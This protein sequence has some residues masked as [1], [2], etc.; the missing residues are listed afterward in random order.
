MKEKNKIKYMKL[1]IKVLVAILVVESIFLGY[2]M[3]MNRKNS[4]YYTIENDLVKTKDGYV[5]VGLSDM[6]YSKLN[7]YKKPGYTKATI[8]KLDNKFNQKE[9]K[10]LSIGYNS[11]Y[12]H[13]IETKDGYVAVGAIEMSKKHHEDKETEA[14]IVKY[15]KDLNITWRKNL[16][17]LDVNEFISVKEDS[18]GNYIVV[19]K[20]VYGEGY[21]GNH[22]TGGA[23]LLRYNSEG[24]ETLRI[25]YGG[26]QSG[27]FNDIIVEDDGYVVVGL[28]STSTGVIK[29]Y[30]KTGKE[31]W[32]AYYGYTD[33]Q[34]I[35]SIEKHND[36]YYVTAT[37]LKEK[38]SKEYST[39]ILVFDNNGKRL[40]EIKY[41]NEKINRLIDLTVN[42]KEIVAVG[43]TVKS[44][45]NIKSSGIVLKYNLDLKKLDEKK[46]SGENDVTFNKIYNIDN[47]YII[48]G[49]TNS[50]LKGYNKN[51]KDYKTVH[52]KY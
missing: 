18:E 22:T 4:T 5:A 12:N 29:K 16:N 46:Y 48:L 3:I 31:L 36:K 52:I 17:I 44:S 6:K 35:T 23:I 40:N 20:S 11:F 38:T 10:Y 21:L 30:D 32:H 33:N 34:G 37:K 19:G 47:N 2:K 26:P 8:W 27:Q 14:T 39:S 28:Y 24:E 49:N 7:D 25:N 42:D 41:K 51:N 1:I 43:I 45:T 13:V 9:E 50:K 15:D